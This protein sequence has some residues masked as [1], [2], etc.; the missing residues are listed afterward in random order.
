MYGENRHVHFSEQK[1]E[2]P[3]APHFLKPKEIGAKNIFEQ[4]LFLKQL[5]IPYRSG[6]ICI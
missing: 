2:V 4:L 5:K 6:D 3:A 1:C